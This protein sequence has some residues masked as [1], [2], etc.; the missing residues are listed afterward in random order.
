[1]AG[2]AI[3]SFSD[4]TEAFWLGVT[5][6]VIVIVYEAVIE[7]FHHNVYPRLQRIQMSD[8]ATLISLVPITVFF[9]YLWFQAYLIVIKVLNL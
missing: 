6:T 9:V 8:K 7:L 5:T 1:M 4:T 2:F 3:L